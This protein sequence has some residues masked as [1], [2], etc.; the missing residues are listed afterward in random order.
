MRTDVEHR[1]RG[2]GAA[3]R[4]G[5]AAVCALGLVAVPACA[6]ADRDEGASGS[7]GPAQGMAEPLPLV[8]G[9]V[10]AVERE[11]LETVFSEAGVVGT[12][13]LYDVRER[14]ATVV[15]PEEA[16]ERAAPAATFAVPH[17]LIAL[18]T[19][20]VGDVD[21]VLTTGEPA[22]RRERAASLREA[23]PAADRDVYRE[24][25]RRLGPERTAAWL[26][27]FDY[28]NR[29]VGGAED[30]ERFW[31]EGPLEISALEQTSF[32]ASLALGE[33]PVDTEHRLTI[34]EVS[35]VEE[36]GDYTLY[37]VP[38]RAAGG[39]GPGWWVGWVERDEALYTFA[40]RVEA[41]EGKESPERLGRELLV[42][43]EVLPPEA[44][45]N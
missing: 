7:G 18:Q 33:L 31:R 40:L 19:G 41:E 44:A 37:A 35:A 25:A 27:R 26:D 2:G 9:D 38:E 23:L 11:E 6:A 17:T 13:V 3:L 45:R 4:A 30:A 34:R 21:E 36:G 12:L 1:Q 28:G 32:L 15:D 29:S 42:R 5:L 39:D 24:V 20:A 14:T 43:T 10:P 8:R 16:R 22:A